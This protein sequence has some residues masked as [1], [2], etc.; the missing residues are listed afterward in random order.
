[1]NEDIS[2]M[3]KKILREAFGK[4]E[5]L[6]YTAK[7]NGIAIPRPRVFVL[8]GANGALLIWPGRN[9]EGKLTKHLFNINGGQGRDTIHI[10]FIHE[11]DVKE[12]IGQDP[13]AALRVLRQAESLLGWVK[14]REEGVRRSIEEKRRQQAHVEEYLNAEI[15]LRKLGDMP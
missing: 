10:S 3:I 1:M 15:A 2:R 11:R 6:V 9:D 7:T 8:R 14:A 5:V 4:Y 13:R 12:I